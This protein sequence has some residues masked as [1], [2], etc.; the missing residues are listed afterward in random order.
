MVSNSNDENNRGRFI[1]DADLSLEDGAFKCFLEDCMQSTDYSDQEIKY[2]VYDCSDA[3]EGDFGGWSDRIAGIL[4][5]FIISILAK[6]RFLI[7]FDK[8]CSLNEYFIPAYFDWRYDPSILW[9]K[10]SSYH[11]LL[12]NNYKQI[13]KYMFRN[14]DI[15]TFFHDDVIF[16]RMNWDFMKEF[17][18]RPNIGNVVP[19]IARYHQAD[20]YKH[21]VDVFFKLS[22]S[23]LNALDKQ[24][25]ANRI[26]NKLACAHVRYGNNPNMPRDGKQPK[27]PLDGL[28]R[29]FD[30]LNKDEYGMFVASD[31]D[32]VKALARERYPANIIDTP[33][34]IT[35][36]DQPHL[37][38]QREGFVKQLLDFYT[39]VS[40]DI[41]IIP[42]SGF[43]ILAAFVRNTDSGLY[44]WRGQDFLPCSRYTIGDIFPVGKYGIKH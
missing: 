17:R 1:K 42:S 15:N 40:C 22:P 21:F 14:E 27:L 30:K 10:T 9:N 39:L 19:W 28:W 20:I 26:R 41:L 18:T 3:W 34:N 36:I 12:N 44:C 25:R 37:N 32:N 23:S 13:K 4:T 7:N 24:Y 11:K 16:L 8:P 5:T 31:T 35:H 43:S 38:D 33:G 2:I 6:R 29:Y